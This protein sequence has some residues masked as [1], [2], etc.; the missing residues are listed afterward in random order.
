MD[1]EYADQRLDHEK[2]ALKTTFMFN[3]LAKAIKSN[4]YL[5]PMGTRRILTDFLQNSCVPQNEIA[6][7]P[8]Y[9]TEQ[10]RPTPDT[11]LIEKNFKPLTPLQKAEQ[12]K[13]GADAF[14]QS[15]S[16]INNMH[17]SNVP[18]PAH[19]FSEQTYQVNMILHPIHV[20]VMAI[21]QSKRQQR[22]QP[23]QP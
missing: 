12:L 3:L 13:K 1:F 11:P 10:S 14:R 22:Q 6:A 8:G 21:R 23:G 5:E 19:A 18:Q 7:Y 2:L 4:D 17:S 9:F 20:I 16:H 15:M